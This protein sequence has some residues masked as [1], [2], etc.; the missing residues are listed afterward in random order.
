[1]GLSL[2]KFTIATMKLVVQFFFTLLGDQL[3]EIG[4]MLTCVGSDKPQ[5]PG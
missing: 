3:N 4:L 1:M 5:F 2:R